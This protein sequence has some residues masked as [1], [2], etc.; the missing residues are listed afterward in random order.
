MTKINVT[1]TAS[2]DSYAYGINDAGQICGYYGN[3][4]SA[5]RGFTVNGSTITTGISAFG[6][7]TWLEKINNA[8]QIVGMANPIGSQRAFTSMGGTSSYLGSASQVSYA[9]ALNAAGLIVGMSGNRP[10]IFNGDGTVTDL[11]TWGG[12]Q[13]R[14]TSV[15]NAGVI[16]GYAETTT[17]DVFGS[18]L[19]HAFSYFN[20]SKADLGTIG[21]PNSYADDINST[22]W[23][24]GASNPATSSSDFRA[25]LYKDGAIADLNTLIDPTSGW[26]LESGETIN[27]LGMIAGYGTHNGA[28]STFLLVPVGVPEPGSG[29]MALGGLLIATSVARARRAKPQPELNHPILAHRNLADRERGF[30]RCS[31]WSATIA[32]SLTSA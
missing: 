23:I 32:S 30:C 6:G 18:N 19:N 8:G 29:G 31:A 26:I 22:G 28:R 11:G 7:P 15:N 5:V 3:P 10:V 1:G 4:S 9:M 16:V 12:P 20:G 14:A 13:G 27:D 2:A 17:R 24:V 25:F 21:G